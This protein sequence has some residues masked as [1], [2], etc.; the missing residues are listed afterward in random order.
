MTMRARDPRVALTITVLVLLEELLLES[1][2][3][4]GLFGFAVVVELEVELEG[5]ELRPEVGLP[6][7][8]FVGL[9]WVGGKGSNK[10]TKDWEELLNI[11]NEAGAGPLFPYPLLISL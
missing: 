10:E 5:G 7:C 8:E 4:L 2:L 9:V 6:V 11:C 1:P 3:G